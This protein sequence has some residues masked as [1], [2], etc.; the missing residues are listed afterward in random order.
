MSKID[1]KTSVP[2][3]W[4][5]LAGVS[6]LTWTWIGATWVK[7]VNDRLTRIEQ[8]LGIT[9]DLASSP[10]LIDSAKADKR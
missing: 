2:L 7:G 3:M 1:E 4:V 9:V 10:S 6:V 8:K 5:A